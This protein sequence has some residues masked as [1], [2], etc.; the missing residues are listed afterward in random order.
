MCHVTLHLESFLEFLHDD[1]SVHRYCPIIPLV[2][3][4]GADG[5]GT[6]WSTSLPNY[7]IREV[8]NN[9]RRMLEGDEPREMVGI[10]KL[11]VC[12]KHV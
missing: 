2:L 4:N 8:V 3:I 12:L 10:Q 7:D 11:L 5:I 1:I 6:G 9:L